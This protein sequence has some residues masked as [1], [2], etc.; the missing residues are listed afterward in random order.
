MPADVPAL[1]GLG[2]IGSGERTNEEYV[3]RSSLIDRAVLLANLI[4]SC[5]G[6]REG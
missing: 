6:K 3:L 2:P 4:L 1:D 5:E